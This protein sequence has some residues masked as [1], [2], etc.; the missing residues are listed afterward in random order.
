MTPRVTE[1]ALPWGWLALLVGIV[2]TYFFGL[3]SPFA[4]TNGDEM[5][6]IHIARL[7]AL[8]DHWLPLV[9]DLANMRNTKP[10]LLFWQAMVA[11]DWG[12]NWSLFALR[13][14]SVV[15]TLLTATLI[16]LIARRMTGN[17]RTALVASVLYLLFFSTF[18]YGR[19]FLTSGPETFW[20]SLPMFWLLWLQCRQPQDDRVTDL[21]WG[22]FTAI[23][24][25]M[26]LGMAYKS[27]ALV[28]PVAASLWCAI[29]WRSPLP[30]WRQALRTTA[31]TTWSAALALGLF[32][33]W[34]AL[35][36]DPGAVWK[37]FV[38]GENAGKL[39]GERGYWH[40][41]LSGDYPM[42]S[43]L[44]AYPENAGL[45]ALV[46]LGWVVMEA[47]A[48][49]KRPPAER[50]SPASRVLWI[51]LLVWLVV[52][53]L[54]S[55]RSARYV[56]PAMPAVAI[57]M[58]LSWDR[59]AKPWFWAT[60]LLAIAALGIMARVGWVMGE[61]QI[62]SM[63]QVAMTLIAACAG[64]TCVAAGFIVK[65][66]ARNASLASCLSVY[67][68]FGL[69]TAPL[70]SHEA[71]YADTLQ[72]S[73][74]DR[75][76]AV[77]NGF[78][79]QYERYH[80]LL[81]HSIVV[82]YDAEGRNTGALQPDLHPDERLHYLLD[83]FDAVVW[84]QDRPDRVQPTCWPECSVLGSRWHVKSRHKS[85]E[86]TLANVWHPQEW[87]FRREWLLKKP[88]ASAASP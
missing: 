23:G 65:T 68:T 16:G 53:S 20:F 2:G 15:Y 83:R 62:A 1:H 10:P 88:P 58:A 26:G 39:S 50:I 60:L 5:V 78:T 40:A 56:I 72:N 81:P 42:W 9:S 29:L 33:L 67:L 55:Q 75:R 47:R 85:G 4:P 71:G 19:V 7:T 64:F 32:A 25:S 61:M 3:G 35:D 13:L 38:V 51:W 87:L 77:P 22:V 21:H 37:E 14:P 63:P 86:V 70:G 48:W 24:I 84:L 18:R 59:V 52:F 79:G 43:Q 57:L 74:K 27:F 69:M 8:S 30:T 54:P 41:A 80:F 45:L 12:Q 31:G 76:V 28:A 44:L 49:M 82:P 17:L 66:W 36:P 46:V 6:Y 34:F 11:G 73:L